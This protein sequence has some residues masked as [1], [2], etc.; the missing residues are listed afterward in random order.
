MALDKNH[1]S[2]CEVVTAVWRGLDI[3][4]GERELLSNNIHP[5][6]TACV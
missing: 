4:L 2:Y 6:D 5:W 3:S 1:Q